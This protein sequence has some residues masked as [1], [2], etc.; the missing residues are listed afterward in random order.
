MPICFTSARDNVGVKELME[1][2]TKY[3]PNPL[4]GN[5]R[6]FEYGGEDVQTFAP[7]ADPAK[8]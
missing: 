4:E 2:M 3:C 8:R 6:P 5:P 7:E 1:V